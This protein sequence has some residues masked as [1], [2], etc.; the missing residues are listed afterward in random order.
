M[1]KDSSR[2]VCGE[3]GAIHVKWLGRCTTCNAWGSLAEE[4]APK[5]GASKRGGAREK[6]SARPVSDV[7]SEALPRIPTGIGE[8]D[9]VLGGGAVPGG[10]VL[11]GGDPGVGKSTLL[12]QALGA[13]ARQGKTALYV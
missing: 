10:V 13:I 1:G 9:R 7:E 8:L 12:L 6:P 5:A 11:V 4:A 3:C 2:F